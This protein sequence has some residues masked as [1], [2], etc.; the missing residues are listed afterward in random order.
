MMKRSYAAT[1]RCY[2]CGKWE[3]GNSLPH[4]TFIIL[5]CLLKTLK[6]EFFSGYIGL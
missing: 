1:K 6:P 4:L 3:G 5:L 2:G